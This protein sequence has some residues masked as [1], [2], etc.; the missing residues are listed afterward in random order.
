MSLQMF[1]T[2]FCSVRTNNAAERHVFMVEVTQC[3]DNINQIQK[4][5]LS[6]KVRPLY[7]QAHNMSYG[8]GIHSKSMFIHVLIRRI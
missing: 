3:L 8:Y 4:D 2:F 1:V 7:D 5:P 6:Q